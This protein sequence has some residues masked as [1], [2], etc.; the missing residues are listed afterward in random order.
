[1]LKPLYIEKDFK[2][3]EN[4]ETLKKKWNQWR[5]ICYISFGVPKDKFPK[6]SFTSKIKDQKK[7]SLVIIKEYTQDARKTLSASGK[8]GDAFL[9]HL[10]YTLGLRTGEIRLLKFDDVNNQEHPTIKVY[11]THEGKVKQIEISQ[12]LYDEIK[13]YENKLIMKEKYD[14]T[15]RKTTESEEVD[16]HF[17]YTDSE[18]VI[19]KK[20]RKNFGGTLSKFNL[21]P[22]FIRE[23]SLKEKNNGPKMIKELSLS[24]TSNIRPVKMMKRVSSKGINQGKTSKKIK[25][26][27]II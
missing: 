11:K 24:E 8:I 20:I 6:I 27:K 18:S 3:S 13:N 19:I 26:E 15:I 7:V 21:R 5:R 14:K 4:K 1:M 23:L 10:M 2:Q 9:I 12:A 16:G 22:K 17:M 25:E